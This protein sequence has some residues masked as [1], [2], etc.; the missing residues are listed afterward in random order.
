[1]VEIRS[2]G[3]PVWLAAVALGAC[4]Q[5]AASPTA[6]TRVQVLTQADWDDAGTFAARA[7]K[8]AGVPTRDPSMSSPRFFSMTLVCADIA[9]C[10]AAVQRLVEARSEVAEV[11]PDLRRTIPRPIQPAASA[12]R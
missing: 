3:V 6:T 11:R 10:D 9:A 2:L 4:A 7:S 1:M 8:I 5:P 12:A